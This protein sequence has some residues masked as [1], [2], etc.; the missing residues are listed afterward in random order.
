MVWSV[1]DVGK[2]ITTLLDNSLP[3]GIP[4]QSTQK[5]DYF[6]FVN[7]NP[8]SSVYGRVW[9]SPTAMYVGLDFKRVDV[10]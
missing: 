4:Q 6:D 9:R 1:R 8:N 5:S 10:A 7:H 3:P 2:S